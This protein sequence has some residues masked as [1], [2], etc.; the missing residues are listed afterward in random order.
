MTE[1]LNKPTNA[2]PASTDEI[3]AKARQAHKEVEE[4]AA[5]LRE[6]RI[7]INRKH[8]VVS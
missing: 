7:N 6:E 5:D 1:L 4:A 2:M 8:E 3:I